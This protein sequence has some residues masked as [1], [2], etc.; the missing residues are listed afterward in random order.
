MNVMP[1]SRWM[2]LSSIC[3]AW[4]SLRS[5]APSGSSS[6]RAL[7]IVGQRPG[8]RHAL[9]LPAG[10]LRRLPVGELRQPD[11]RQQ[12][13]HPR[14]RLPGVHLLAPG[15]EGDVV[16]DG[17][18]GEERVVLKDGVDVAP[19]GR[20]PRDVLAVEQNPSGGGQLEARDHPQRG[21]LA[22]A[23]GAEQREEL[24]ALDGEVGL[25][26]RDVAAEALDD[27]LERDDRIAA[28]SGWRGR[29]R[30][31][32]AEVLAVGILAECAPT[33]GS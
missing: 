2:R 21:G 9:L 26:D 32:V 15:P 30:T 1:T 13:L 6:S 11:D 19:I 23:R 24:A 25:L 14:G 18:V 10:E 33:S 17:H 7:G 27:V 22:A 29:R 16:G 31:S 3:I 8:Q 28:A 12:L 5:S 4:R 20:D